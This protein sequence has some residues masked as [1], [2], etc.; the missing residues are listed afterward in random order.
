M[1][2]WGD[3]QNGTYKNPILNADY[4]DPDVIR[5]GNDFY[6]VCSEFHFMGIPVLHSKD[7]VNWQII[8]RVYDRFEANDIYNNMEAY[9][10][11][12]WAPTIRCFN[13]TFYVYFCT[14]CDGLYVCTAKNAEGPW[15]QPYEIKAV[16]NWE[17]PCPFWDDDGQAYLGHSVLL[18]GPIIIHKMSPDGKSL[19]D[20]GTVVYWGPTAEGTKIY[21]R[22]GY[23]YIIIPEGGVGTGW[24]TALRSKNIYGPYERKVVLEEGTSN[25]NGPH[26]G[27]LVEL[28]SGESWFV[29]FQL[30]S[31]NKK[32]PKP[33]GRVC[34]LQP[35]KWIEDW[36]MMGVCNEGIWEPVW[37]YKKPN[38]GAEYPVCFPATSDSFEEKTLSYQW[39]FNHNPVESKWS[40]TER[41]GYLR[42]ISSNAKDVMSA[43]NTVTQKVMG[44]KGTAST[45]L[46]LE[47]MSP[48][49]IAGLVHIN[50]KG[51]WIGIEKADES[52][53][54]VRAYINE[55]KYI[56]PQITQQK[57]WFKTEI[58]AIGDTYM[59]YSLD[60]IGFTQ[61]G[62]PLKLQYG[63]WK[64]SKI[65]LFTF[66]SE[67]GCVDFSWFN[68]DFSV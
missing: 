37:Q 7:L 46:C 5:V 27:G 17:D 47:N 33:L 26:Q 48:G 54:V 1:K 19:L 21:K 65:G 61:L 25:M 12:S 13:G 38:V 64:G 45:E 59:L 57:I 24:Q 11:G 43:R 8:S 4:S 53:Y 22:N 36:P 50:K 35:V 6:M 28:E 16:K 32:N 39:A 49:Q 10:K 30:T 67:E 23:Y 41:P 55:T 66:G 52:S 62:G 31:A 15:T 68:Y 42:L 20:E 63:Y 51:D 34:H 60:N 9:G 14:P 2:A 58:D 29:H 56:G 44:D 3:Q 18:G 40:L